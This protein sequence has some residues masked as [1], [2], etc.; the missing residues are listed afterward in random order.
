M[1]CVVFD[2]PGTLTEDGEPAITD[3]AKFTQDDEK[4]LL[5]ITKIREASSSH[6]VAKAMVSLC[7]SRELY[8][9]DVS[10][11]KEFP[12]KGINGYVASN[13]GNGQLNQ[14]LVGNE[15][16]LADHSVYIFEDIVR[17]LN[18]WKT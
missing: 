17:I 13:S 1:G 16:F 15:A 3:Q 12:G 11:L 5:S 9:I 10:H 2:K 4:Q 8:K 7:D 6:S 18:V 14:V